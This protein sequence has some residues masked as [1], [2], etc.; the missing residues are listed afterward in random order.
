MAISSVLPVSPDYFSDAL[1]LS[2]LAN[3]SQHGWSQHRLFL[4]E[5]LRML[6]AAECGSL[7]ASGALKPAGVGR[8]ALLTL[9]PAIRGDQILWLNPGQ[10]QACDDYLAIMESLRLVL[11]QH[12][13]LGLE[14]YE[15]HFA[16]YA[17]GSAYRQHLDRFRDDDSRTVS[18]VIYLNQDWL[19]EQGGALRLHPQGL[20][21]QDVLP[22]GAT[23]V[24]FLSAEMLHEVLP[25]TRDR[26][27]LTGWFRR[28]R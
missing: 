16:F 5:T 12:F 13:Y 1:Q 28:R 2:M 18:V 19:S 25:A 3:L 23:M 15:S 11:N 21:S 26:L 20:A 10:S 22:T 8:T 14:E 17:P 9:Q 6:L 24:L 4:P 27:S 7:A